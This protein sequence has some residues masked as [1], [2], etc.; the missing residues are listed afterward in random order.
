MCSSDLDAVWLRPDGAH[1]ALRC[2]W[3]QAPDSV[4]RLIRFFLAWRGEARRMRG[5]LSA[6][7]EEGFWAANGMVAEGSP[8]PQLS[9]PAVG[10]HGYAGTTHGFVGVGLPLG[11]LEA[12]ILD[13]LAT[14]AERFGDGSLRVTPWRLL[15][16]P[17]VARDDAAELLA[18]LAAAGGITEPGDP[19]LRLLVCPGAPNCASAT[20]DTGADAAGLL[21]LGA[22]PERGLLHLSGCGKGC[23]HPGAAEA[24]LVG[25]ADGRYGLVRGGTAR[26]LPEIA[27]LTIEEAASR[28]QATGDA[29]GGEVA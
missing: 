14:L 20:V 22:V 1:G 21:A 9:A 25:G 15:L 11:R 13:R 23:A 28:L 17:G 5:L 12:G 8:A 24:V 10:F 29:Q 3:E 19:R 26:D 7:G 2:R 27:G 18:L 16:L 6:L 4:G